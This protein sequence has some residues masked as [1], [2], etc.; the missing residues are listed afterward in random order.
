M[1]NRDRYNIYVYGIKLKENMC[2]EKILIMSW[3][4]YE[5]NSPGQVIKNKLVISLVPFQTMEAYYLA[6]L[7]VI[8]S[9]NL[10][11]CLS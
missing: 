4:N 9:Y 6:M 11:I 3:T 2:G 7:V 1:L 10:I 5:N 8:L